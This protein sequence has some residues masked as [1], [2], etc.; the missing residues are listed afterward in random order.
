MQTL[1]GRTW[2]EGWWRIA[3]AGPLPIRVIDKIEDSPSVTSE[4]PPFVLD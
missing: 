1:L 2:K 4:G 3:Q